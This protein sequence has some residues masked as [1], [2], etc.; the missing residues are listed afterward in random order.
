MLDQDFMLLWELITKKSNLELF[1][2]KGFKE[3]EL[4]CT[5]QLSYVKNLRDVR[6]SCTI[7]PD[8]SFYFQPAYH[9]NT[10]PIN[11]FESNKKPLF[12]SYL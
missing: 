1:H 12:I 2:Q 3:N 6:I 5:H 8:L 10:N 11:I 9:K 7:W 4:E